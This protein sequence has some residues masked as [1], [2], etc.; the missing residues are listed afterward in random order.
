MRSYGSIES[1]ATRKVSLVDALA[2]VFIGSVLGY[3][4]AAVV[5]SRAWLHG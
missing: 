5:L 2:L 1:V 4:V 3:L